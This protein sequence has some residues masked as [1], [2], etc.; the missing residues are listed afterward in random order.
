VKR[1][2][3]GLRWVMRMFRRKETWVVK[4]KWKSCMWRGKVVV[5][6]EEEEEEE[7]ERKNIFYS[8][9]LLDYFFSYFF[10][11]SF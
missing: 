8:L 4:K 10:C 3:R 9:Y 1:I 11:C 2:E 5:R 7:E 6:W